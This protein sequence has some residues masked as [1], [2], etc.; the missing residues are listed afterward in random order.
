M[1]ALLR[2]CA[3]FVLSAFV[4][5]PAYAE[6]AEKAGLT[7][8]SALETTY[9]TN[10][11]LRAARKALRATYEQLPQAYSGWQPTVTS[12]AS[13]TATDIAGSNFGP[14]DGST[15]KDVDVGFDQPL[16]RGF[17]TLA[18]TS[19]AKSTITSQTAVLVSTEQ[20]VLLNAVTAYMDVVRDRALLDLSLNNRDVLDKQREATQDRFDVGELTRTDVSQAKARLA[21]ADSDVITAKGT[22]NSSIAVFEQIIGEP[23]ENLKEAEVALSFPGTLDEAVGLAE[24]SNPLV[25]GATYAHKAAEK[26]ADSIFGEL[27]PSIGLF[28]SWNRTFDP[29]P[30]LVPEQTTKAFGVSATIPLYQAGAVRSRLRQVKH[31]ANSRYMEILEVKR[32]VRQD[33]ITA[34]S[35]W[36]SAQSEIRSR[37]LQVEASRIARN[38]VHAE[39]DVGTRT[40]LD[41]LDADQELLDAQVALVTAQRD[42]VV[43]K[44]TLLSTLGL[45]TPET[46]GFS[47]DEQIS[48]ED[49]RDIR[50]KFFDLHVDRL[51]EVD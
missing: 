32:G 29:A 44:F 38:G 9:S 3:V 17:R 19:A 41:S 31:T 21:R 33:V 23:P 27:L 16:F 47:T 7:L 34:W 24:R 4:V 12:N 48:N 25:I 20:D 46:L 39:A 10:P 28:G 26:D 8:L 49:L 18:E 45:L 22:L 50:K 35:D 5:L 43:A 2:Y 1:N 42:E 37:E 14:A 30:G 13:L 11:T 15:A 36:R 51:Q 6:E 40:I